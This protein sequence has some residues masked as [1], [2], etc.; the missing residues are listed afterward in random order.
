LG[1]YNQPE[2][3]KK[4]VSKEG[5]LYTGDMGYFKQMA[6]YKALYLSGRRKFVI[7]QKGYNVFPG[8][9]EEYISQMV[10]V[11]VVEVIGMKHELFDEGIIAFVRPL[12]GVNLKSEDVIEHCKSIASYKRP[13]HVE[14]WPTDKELPLTRST[15]V[16]K[17]KLA[18][19]ALPIVENLRSMGKWDAGSGLNI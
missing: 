8:E 10:G 17:L 5:I 15:K 1:Y 14:I 2:E 6:G 9:V 19:L 13:Q 3:T 7:K 12:A 16:D 4:A 11:D 18:E